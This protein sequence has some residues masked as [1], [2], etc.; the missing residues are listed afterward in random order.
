MIEKCPHCLSAEV[1]RGKVFN[2]IGSMGTIYFRPKRLKILS[3]GGD[4]P[5]P[6]RI[7]F[8]CQKCGLVWNRVNAERLRIVIRNN[9]KPSMEIK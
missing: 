6:D 4:V 9:V 8:A 5:F 3:W 2:V 1:V 7:F